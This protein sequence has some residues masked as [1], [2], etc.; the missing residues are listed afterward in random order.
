[1]V[2]PVLTLLQQG[3]V[4]QVA[5]ML[6]LIP[7]NHPHPL[8]SSGKGI[9]EGRDLCLL[10][11]LYLVGQGEKSPTSG[12]LVYLGT[13]RGRLTY[14]MRGQ[15]RAC[16]IEETCGN[17]IAETMQHRNYKKRPC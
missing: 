16:D 15:H 9:E 17:C 8:I 11:R 12:S 2:T 10:G 6:L 4:N 1:M 14:A 5:S 7:R 3:E 13:D